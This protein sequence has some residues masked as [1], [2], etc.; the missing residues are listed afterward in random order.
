MLNFL[1]T[2]TFSIFGAFL[3]FMVG[4]LSKSPEIVFIATPIGALLGYKFTNYLATFFYYLLKL[5]IKL[6]PKIF[7]Q[8][9]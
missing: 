3:G 6:F 8:V 9:D 5:V 1:K 2:V 4:R 7:K